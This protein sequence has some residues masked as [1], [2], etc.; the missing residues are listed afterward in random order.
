VSA[1]A[2]SGNWKLARD[3]NLVAGAGNPER[4]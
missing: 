1:K 2:P 3:A 4:V